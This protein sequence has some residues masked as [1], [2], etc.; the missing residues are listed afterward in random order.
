MENYSVTTNNDFAI[1]NIEV[2]AHNVATYAS[3]FNRK[4]DIYGDIDTAVQDAENALLELARIMNM[5]NEEY[6]NDVEL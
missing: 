3:F 2:M 6:K 1:S 4:N 5:I